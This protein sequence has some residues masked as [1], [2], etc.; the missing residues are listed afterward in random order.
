MIFDKILFKVEFYLAVFVAVA[1][2][3]FL[4]L[5]GLGR[6][7]DASERTDFRIQR[8]DVLSQLINYSLIRSAGGVIGLCTKYVSRRLLV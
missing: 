7:D 6:R 5:L 4:V 2:P 8:Q 3:V 1:F